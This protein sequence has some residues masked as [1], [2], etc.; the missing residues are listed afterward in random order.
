MR[1]GNRFK[2]NP[3]YD[4]PKKTTEKAVTNVRE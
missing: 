3:I 1:L 4:S 2:N